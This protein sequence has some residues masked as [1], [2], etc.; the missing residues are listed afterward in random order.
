MLCS[1][2]TSCYVTSLKHLGQKKK[3]NSNRICCCCCFSFLLFLLNGS[4]LEG[5]TN[6][7]KRRARHFETERNIRT[8]L[9]DWHKNCFFS[10]SSRVVVSRTLKPKVSRSFRLS[11]QCWPKQVVCFLRLSTQRPPAGLVTIMSRVHGLQCKTGQ[12]KYT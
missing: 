7:K 4:F 6:A 11:C 8:D 10:E 5:E 1:K 3:K 12:A 9:Q 2:T